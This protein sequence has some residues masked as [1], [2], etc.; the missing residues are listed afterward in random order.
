MSPNSSTSLKLGP[1]GGAEVQWLLVEVSQRS[2]GCQRQPLSAPLC[3]GVTRFVLPP[4]LLLDPWGQAF[5]CCKSRS[6]THTLPACSSQV[7]SGA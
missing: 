7:L 2:L 1:E 5:P 3:L 6:G 4:T